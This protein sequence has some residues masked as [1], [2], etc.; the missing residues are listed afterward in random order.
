[1]DVLIT[2]LMIVALIHY[3]YDRI[4]LPTLRQKS[5]SNIFALRD[6][7]RQELITNKESYSPETIKLFKVMDDR[8]NHAVNRLHVFTL[9]NYVKVKM[10]PEGSMPEVD[11]FRK[12]LKECESDVLRDV[13]IKLSGEILNVLGVNSLLMCLWLLPIVVVASIIEFI[14]G[15][16]GTLIKDTTVDLTDIVTGNRYN[17]DK[18]A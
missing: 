11:A 6:Q 5:R 14:I 8:I 3:V 18:H 12:R 17:F 13:H 1:M 2:A 16:M 15:S 7:L 4:V 9:T 10:M